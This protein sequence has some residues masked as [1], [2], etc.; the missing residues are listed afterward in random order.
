MNAIE[1]MYDQRNSRI[2]RMRLFAVRENR[3]RGRRGRRGNSGRVAFPVAPGA[4]A[5]LE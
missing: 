3:R 2:H 1:G 5:V 4:A